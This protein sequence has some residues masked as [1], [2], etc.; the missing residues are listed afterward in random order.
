MVFQMPFMGCVAQQSSGAKA[1]ASFSSEDR[2]DD[3]I[4]KQSG[5]SL[6]P[7][8][9]MHD[10]KHVKCAIP[11]NAMQHVDHK[12]IVLHLHMPQKY[13]ILFYLFTQLWYKI[14]SRSFQTLF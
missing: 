10:Q 14:L 11:P 9:D 3:D 12:C 5:N 13:F 1:W 4:G 2:G 7:S 6:M 8:L